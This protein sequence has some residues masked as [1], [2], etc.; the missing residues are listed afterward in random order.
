[1]LDRRGLGSRDAG[2]GQAQV[3]WEAQVSP[4]QLGPGKPTGVWLTCCSPGTRETQDRCS[5]NAKELA[6]WGLSGKDPKE[7]SSWRMG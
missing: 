1:M 4:A 5:T 6:A 7:A 3:T 2:A